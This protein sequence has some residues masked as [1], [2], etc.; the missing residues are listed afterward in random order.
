M[1]VLVDEEALAGRAALPSAQERSRERRL[2]GRV[3]VSVVED[4]QGAVSAHLEQQRLAGGALSD[5]VPGG[6][7]ADEADRVRACVCCN[8]V[9][10][11]RARAR[12]EVEDTGG[13]LGVR[14]ALGQLD[15]AYRGR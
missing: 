7:R 8:L 5:A 13:K 10:D 11:D 4:D 15:G 3:E 6:D 2:D 12:Y 14:D 1:N 9:S